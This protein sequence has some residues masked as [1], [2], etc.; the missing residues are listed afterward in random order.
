[1]RARSCGARRVCPEHVAYGLELFG[2]TE[3]RTTP[4][5][6]AVIPVEGTN[7]VASLQVEAPSVRGEHGSI[8]PA[9]ERPSPEQ[10]A[11]AAPPDLD[12]L[13]PRRR[14]H[15]HRWIKV[16]VAELV[17]E[18]RAEP[19][20]GRTVPV[21]RPRHERDVRRI[22]RGQRCEPYEWPRGVE[23]PGST[24]RSGHDRRWCGSEEPVVVP[25][26]RYED[27]RRARRRQHARREQAPSPKPDHALVAV[28][29]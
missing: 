10:P 25:Q 16:T 26:P 14:C 2:I 6:A 29:S 20:C 11:I 13:V 12:N 5:E 3:D 21:P 23:R 8:V 19:L 28:A 7:L 15:R 22:R 9:E 4:E 18:G 17:A 1:M 24:H 27:E